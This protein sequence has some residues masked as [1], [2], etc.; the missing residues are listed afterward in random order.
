[1][2]KITMATLIILITQSSMAEEDWQYTANHHY[3][4]MVSAINMPKYIVDGETYDFKWQL[5]GYL[6]EYKSNV[7]FYTNRKGK[8]LIPDNVSVE[9]DTGWSYRGDGT[10]I[11]LFNYESRDS[12]NFNID[13]PTELKL[14]FYKE[15]PT[16]TV[17][18]KG[19]DP[20]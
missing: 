12:L 18:V 4:A 5:T 19:S 1:M 17:K 8:V 7:K 14:R 10:N 11:K 9:I 2:K 15:A 13:E 20:K 6:D 16:D 3:P